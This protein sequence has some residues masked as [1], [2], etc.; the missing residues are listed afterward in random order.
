MNREARVEP[1]C[2]LLQIFREKRDTGAAINAYQK[3]IGLN[4]SYVEAYLNIA[5]LYM[6]EE[7]YSA[8]EE[9]LK[10]APAT[11]LTGINLSLC[12][13]ASGKYDEAIAL[14]DQEIKRWISRGIG[15]D[16]KIVDRY[17]VVSSLAF[18]SG[19]ERRNSAR[20]Q[21]CKN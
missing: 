8:A 11:P 14:S 4:P 20:R 18:I 15:I 21:N 7:R 16:V 17:P 5:F 12:L 6:S 2:D 1:A 9:V 3:A 19:A 13:M 10:K